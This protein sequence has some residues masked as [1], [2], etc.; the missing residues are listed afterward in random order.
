MAV[1]PDLMNID[2]AAYHGL[3]GLIEN[4]RHLLDFVRTQVMEN[5]ETA[6]GTLGHRVAFENINRTLNGLV[7]RFAFRGVFL[8]ASGETYD[9]LKDAAKVFGGGDVVDLSNYRIAVVQV[10]RN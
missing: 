3:A 9:L 5:R 2:V 8:C 10:I 4:R 7:D 1:V 6:V